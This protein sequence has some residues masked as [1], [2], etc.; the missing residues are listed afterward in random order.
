MY[1]THILWKRTYTNIFSLSMSVSLSLTTTHT[2]ANISTHSL[3]LSLT[4]CRKVVEYNK[5]LILDSQRP[6]KRE[7][8][9]NHNP[10]NHSK[11]DSQFILHADLCVERY[12]G[13]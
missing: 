1:I 5:Q 11:S 6:A 4:Q 8:R 3:A 9:A 7:V 12:G 13:K 10:L 2:H